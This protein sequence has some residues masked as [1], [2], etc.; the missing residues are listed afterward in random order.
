MIIATPNGLKIQHGSFPKEKIQIETNLNLRMKHQY[1]SKL[2]S[3]TK[4][5]QYRLH[6][7]FQVIFNC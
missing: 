6:F 2:M 7:F 1:F 3:Q 4:T 5:D